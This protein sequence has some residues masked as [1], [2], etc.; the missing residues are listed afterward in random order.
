MSLL[1]PH[2]LPFVIALA[3]LAV[4][5][6]VQVTGAAD[7][8]DGAGDADA[9]DGLELGG[10]GDALTALLG[11]GRVPLL[12]WLASLLLM[13][14]SLGLIGQAW[15]ADLLGAPLSAGW[16][17][18]AAGGAALPLNSLAMRPLGAVI[19]KDET[20]AIDLDDLVRRDAEIQIGTARTG[21]PARAKVIDIHGQA[22]FVM[23]EPHDAATELR[24]GDTVLLVRREG[25]TFFGVLYESPLLGL[26]R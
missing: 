4:I 16:A 11:L 14:G 15:I 13:F 2:N 21:S 26:D 1:E 10:L 17:M 23:V 8:L 19:P 12:I 22:H 9:A 3:M 25:Q 18:L 7:L 20:T 5:A 6:L 24:T